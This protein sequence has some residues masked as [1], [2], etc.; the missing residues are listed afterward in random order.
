MSPTLGRLAR[1]SISLLVMCAASGALPPAPVRAAQTILFTNTNDSG[2]GSLRWAIGE[3]Q[4]G[5]TIQAD[6]SILG[7]TIVLDSTLV[8]D[9]DLTI[10]GPFTI[11]GWAHTGT[12]RRALEIA[13]DATVTI[14]SVTVSYS[15]GIIAE[16]GGILNRGTLTFGGGLLFLNLA[17]TRGGA[18]AN[19][20]VATLEGLNVQS[21]GAVNGAAFYNAPG[22]TLRYSGGTFITNNGDGVAARSTTKARWSSRTSR[23]IGARARGTAGPSTT[24]A[25]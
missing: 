13:E 21:N 14:S 19:Y 12:P 18:L 20:G 17:A 22:A 2:E 6:H 11:R 23:S 25:R 7:S 8:V 15:G 4:D 3:A 24:P 9:K 16:G 1:L 10:L 5:D